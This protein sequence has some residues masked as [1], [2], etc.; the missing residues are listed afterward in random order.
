[1][2][3]QISKTQHDGACARPAIGS[4]F[5]AGQVVTVTVPALSISNGLL[6]I[7][8]EWVEMRCANEDNQTRAIARSAASLFVSRET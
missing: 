4:A 5:L 7:G 1:M 8:D 6:A 2:Q 3:A